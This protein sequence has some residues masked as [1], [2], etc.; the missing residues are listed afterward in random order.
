[1]KKKTKP[2]I[3]EESECIAPKIKNIAAKKNHK[4]DSEIRHHIE[5]KVS[6]QLKAS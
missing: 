2:G 6:E 5:K 1:M 3:P 4:S